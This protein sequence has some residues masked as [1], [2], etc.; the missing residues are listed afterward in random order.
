MKKRFIAGMLAS[1]MLVPTMAFA[2][3]AI[4]INDSSSNNLSSGLMDSVYNKDEIAKRLNNAIIELNEAKKSNE[5]ALSFDK[6]LL[7][8]EYTAKIKNYSDEELKQY[9]SQFFVDKSAIETKLVNIKTIPEDDNI[10]KPTY[11]TYN[12]REAEVWTGVPSLGWCYVHIQYN[13][14]IGD[15]SDGRMYD[16]LFMRGKVLTSWQTGIAVANNWKHLD[17]DVRALGNSADITARGL[18]T[19][20]IKGTP[21]SY[22]QDIT[23]LFE[24]SIHNY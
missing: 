17:G 13:I 6:E 16:G 7:T 22:S 20:G 2:D 24:D 4:N 14:L 8:D 18:L 19:W 1:S 15:S 9:L 11:K 3:E 10:I 21:L 23:V 5:G 12:K